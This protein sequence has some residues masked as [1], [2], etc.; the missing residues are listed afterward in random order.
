MGY[1]YSGGDTLWLI[2]LPRVFMRNASRNKISGFPDTLYYP[3]YI[4]S[5]GISTEYPG[6]GYFKMHCARD[7]GRPVD[8]RRAMT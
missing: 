8:F 4:L 7:T 1:Y 3:P 2:D 5:G 6:S